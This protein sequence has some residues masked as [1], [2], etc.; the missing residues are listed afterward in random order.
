MGLVPIIAHELGH[1][2]DPVNPDQVVAER[3]PVRMVKLWDKLRRT[4]VA[5]CSMDG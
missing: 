5:Q 4:E 3:L 2:I 1:L